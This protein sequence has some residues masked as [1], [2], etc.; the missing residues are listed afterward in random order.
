MKMRPRPLSIK[1]VFKRKKN[2]KKKSLKTTIQF[3]HSHEIA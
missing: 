3:S 1:P 2:E